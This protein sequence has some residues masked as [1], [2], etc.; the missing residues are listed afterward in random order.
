[1]RTLGFALSKISKTLLYKYY[2][3]LNF[4]LNVYLNVTSTGAPGQLDLEH[5][6]LLFTVLGT[7]RRFTPRSA[8]S[9]DIFF[10]LLIKGIIIGGNPK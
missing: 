1:M 9:E 6:L 3:R 4:T 2:V 7:N 10:S 8:K 5:E